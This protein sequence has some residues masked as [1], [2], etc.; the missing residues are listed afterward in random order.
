M[1][2]GKTPATEQALP[3]GERGQIAA[4]FARLRQL[5][6][7]KWVMP[8][9]TLLMFGLAVSAMYHMLRETHPQQLLAGLHAM[10]W[11]SLALSVLFMGLSFLFMIGY[12]ASA[13]FYLKKRLPW[14]TVA[15]GAFT[16][17]AFS[18]TVGMAL[19]SGA[20]IRYRIYVEAG[21]DG[22][23]IAKIA[24]FCALAFGIG[25]HVV[26]AAGL[27]LHPEL[28]SDRL[29]IP[30]DVLRG[31]GL[32]GLALA[33][34][35][36]LWL[37]PG[38]RYIKLWKWQLNLP[39]WRLSLI[40]LAITVFDIL[41]SVACL[42]ALLPAGSVPFGTLVLVFVLAA[43]L[44]VASHVPAG[45]GVFE[46]VMIAALGDHVPLAQL[47]VA[48]VLFRV[49][50]YLLPLSL[51]MLLLVWREVRLAQGRAVKSLVEESPAAVPRR[52]GLR[53]PIGAP[54]VMLGDWG[55]RLVPLATA[56]LMFIAGLVVLASA[57][58][59]GVPERLVLLDE[60]L[61]WILVEVSHV[62]AALVG[63]SLLFLARGLQR[64]LNG[65]YALSMLLLGLGIVFNLAKGV[66]FEEAGVLASVALVLFLSRKEFYRRTRLLDSPFSGGWF[67]AVFAALIGMMALTFF[68]FKGVEYSPMLWWQFGLD[69]EAA[70]SLRATLGVGVGVALL[71]L[72][73]LLRPPLR[74]PHTPNA[75]V[76][77]HA[78]AIVSAQDYASAN[79]VLLGDK[80]IMLNNEGDAFI[81]FARQGS[82]FIA[83]GDAVGSPNALEEL[84]WQFR[85][86]VSREGGRIAFYQVRAQN[87]PMYLDMGLTPLKIGEEAVVSLLD[88]ELKGKRHE[89]NRYILN[90]GE[91]VGLAFEYVPAAR[92]DEVFAEVKAVSD[93]WLA[94]RSAREKRF[95]LGWF[96]EDYVRHFD[97]AVLRFEG[98]IVAFVTVLR[99]ATHVELT[100]DIMR[101]LADAPR[102]AMRFLLL[103]LMLHV[104][105]EGVQRFSLAMAPPS[106]QEGH[107][108][109]P[110]WQRFGAAIYQYGGAYYNFSGV[111]QFKEQFYPQ[112]EPRYLVTQ[113]GLDP[114]IILADVAMLVGGGVRGVLGK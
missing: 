3:D 51:A 2:Q 17:Y 98:R 77:A 26:A 106:G 6:S 58:L 110:V 75:A 82:S 87:L 8:T 54:I 34:G 101:Q 64:R 104:K 112:W 71:G 57:A 76:L 30:V 62:L 73:V 32:L 111:R 67:A 99:T 52:D 68:A 79:L 47:M 53:A 13:L 114:A 29:N 65:A 94:Q 9:I 63:L 97:V 18:N 56:G 11:S 27:A 24:A 60:T 33:A 61:P 80:S 81:M 90:R 23:D 66:D 100:T 44:G 59:P 25:A 45:L 88:F 35:I 41:F 92:W 105:A 103:K 46:A 36:V 15:L 107:R 74:V 85:E 109:V 21:L 102:D 78:Q 86:L 55:A 16:G 42:Y 37:V 19:V 20:S 95:S 84:N 39:G 72:M 31:V 5:F 83:L 49:I 14:R 108:Y 28:L 10:P 89:A 70:R 38:P 7:A 43:A 93:A 40:Q 1:S 113:G 50:Y 12:D 69:Q 22:M 48:L 91:R 96:A 4:L